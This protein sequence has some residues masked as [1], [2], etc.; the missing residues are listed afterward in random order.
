[1][2]DFEVERC[3]RHCA[4]SG[5]ALA[6]GE[7]I[8]SVLMSERGSVKRLDYAIEAWHGPP[9]KSLAWWKSKI[10]AADQTTPKLAPSD[11]L[12]QFFVELQQSDD[13][14]DVR[15]VLALLLIRRRIFR[16]EDQIRDE[17]GRDVM[18][19]YCGRNETSYEVTIVVPDDVRVAQIQDELA[20]LLFTSGVKP[21]ATPTSSAS[22]PA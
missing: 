7:E 12:L 3:T 18:V 21:A 6:A 10:P 17:Q 8:Y 1:M 14:A 22:T 4:E 19:V 15:Y 5:R 11:A 2:L 13:K 9:E 20:E 16:L